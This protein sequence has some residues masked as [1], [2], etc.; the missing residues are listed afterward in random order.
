MRV[1][2]EDEENEGGGVSKAKKKSFKLSKRDNIVSRGLV[3]S[4]NEREGE[5]YD[6]LPCASAKKCTHP[7]NRSRT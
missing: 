5:E 4:D 1:Y 6:A 2:R 3:I 7:K